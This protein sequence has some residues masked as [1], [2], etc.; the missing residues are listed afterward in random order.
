MTTIEFTEEMVMNPNAVPEGMREFRYYR[1][2]IWTDDG[3]H[4]P[5]EYGGLWLPKHVDISVVEDAVNQEI[6][7]TTK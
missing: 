4:Y 6:E 5:H 1:A 2:E 3:Q 7:R